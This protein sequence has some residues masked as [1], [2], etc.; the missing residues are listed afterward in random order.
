ML[1]LHGFPWRILLQDPRILYMFFL[2]FP[3]GRDAPLHRPQLDGGFSYQKQC[4]LDT[5][6]EWRFQGTCE[7]T[8]GSEPGTCQ[9]PVTGSADPVRTRKF[10]SLEP[11][12]ILLQDPRILHDFGEARGG[13]QGYGCHP[14]L[15]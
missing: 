10:Q 7:H 14:V 12:R 8:H 2:T 3:H 6:E 13:T 15:Y 1:Q 9:D 4:F 5:A 11:V